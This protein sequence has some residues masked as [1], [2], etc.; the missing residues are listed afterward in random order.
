V[1]ITLDPASRVARVRDYA[2]SHDWSVGG[3]SASIAW[4]FSTG[5]VFFQHEQAR[6]FGAQLDERG[7]LQP[8][9]SYSYKFNLEELK[10]PLRLAVTQAG[11]TWRPV[12]WDGPVWLRWLTE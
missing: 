10:Q 7:N 1:V 2:A 6:V 9:A 5:I 11:W 4:K 8:N 3:G 12:V